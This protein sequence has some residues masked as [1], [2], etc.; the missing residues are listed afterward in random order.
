MKK[1]RFKRLQM[2]H[3]NWKKLT[4]ELF[5]VFLGVTMGFVLNNWQGDQQAA[6]LEQKYQAGFHQDVLSNIEELKSATERDSIWLQ[7]AMPLLESME[8]NSLASD[9]A[10]VVLSLIVKMEILGLHSG[11]YQDMTNSGH[12]NLVSDFALKARLIDY[13]LALEGGAFFDSHFYQYYNDFVMPFIF[14]KVNLLQGE[15]IH[16]EVEH[17]VQFANVFYGYMSMIQQRH[18]LYMDLLTQ[19]QE[20]ETI[21]KIVP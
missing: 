12:F 10:K 20:L 1:I 7:R 3:L 4:L 9:S 17:S 15:F 6:V 21:L 11:T 13:H 18:A 16:T 8:A 14:G 2:D 19:S 5:V